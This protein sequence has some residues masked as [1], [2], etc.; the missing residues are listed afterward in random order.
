[1][2]LL[3]SAQT[4]RPEA[5]ADLAKAVVSIGF[6]FRILLIRLMQAMIRL[7]QG[8]ELMLGALWI[9]ANVE[10]DV[11]VR[12]G[13]SKHAEVGAQGSLEDARAGCHG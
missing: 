4:P 3:Y 2:Y 7:A 8:M 1:M 10:G 9:S 11:P 12:H 6:Q 13:A 5:S